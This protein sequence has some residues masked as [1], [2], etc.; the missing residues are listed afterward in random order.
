MNVFQNKS[1]K[2]S[3]SA[4]LFPLVQWLKVFCVL[5]REICCFYFKNVFDAEME[6]GLRV[7][8]HRR[9]CDIYD[10]FAPHINELTY[11]LSYLPGHRVSDFGRVELGHWSVRQTW[12]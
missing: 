2:V 1:Y 3:P 10:F 9:I 11:L 8:G 5:S 4:V 6:P 7:T 12:C